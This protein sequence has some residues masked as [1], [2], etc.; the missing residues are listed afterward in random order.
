MRKEY[1]RIALGVLYALLPRWVELRGICGPC[2]PLRGRRG[3]AFAD[4]T[5]VEEHLERL[6][7]PAKCGVASV[8]EWK[9]LGQLRAREWAF[10]VELA[11]P[12]S[13]SGVIEGNA[14]LYSGSLFEQNGEL[15]RMSETPRT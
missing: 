15:K 5:R 2:G 13:S 11:L 7:D 9:I 6:C 3:R 10:V 4:W 8:I 1:R 14:E 12:L